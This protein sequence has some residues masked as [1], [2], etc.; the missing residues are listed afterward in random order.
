AKGFALTVRANRNRAGVDDL[1]AQGAQETAD[2]ATLAAHADVIILCVTGSPQVE[3]L[4]EGHQGLLAAG[5]DGLIVI[6]ASTSEPDSTLR[7]GRAFAATGGILVDA[8][9]TRT[10]VEAEAG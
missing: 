3:A 7:L 8:P 2:L 10:P 5:R 1:L 9:L 4:F 6:D